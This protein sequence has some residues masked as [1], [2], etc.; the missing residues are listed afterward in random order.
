MSPLPP[1]ASSPTPSNFTSFFFSL[2]TR[3]FISGFFNTPWRLWKAMVFNSRF[4]G[5]FKNS[6][7]SRISMKSCW[8]LLEV[9]FRWNWT[10]YGNWKIIFSADWKITGTDLRK[11]AS[12]PA[13]NTLKTQLVVLLRNDPAW[14]LQL[15]KKK[16][17]WIGANEQGSTH[18][19]TPR[20]SRYRTHSHSQH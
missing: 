11:C 2:F 20:Y 15:N 19:Q 5:R 12:Q 18:Y 9:L 4:T 13:L 14:V 10:N 8:K 7:K 17:A 16:P 1:L 3:L 6:W